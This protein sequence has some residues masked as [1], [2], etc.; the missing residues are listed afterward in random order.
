MRTAI[1]LAAIG[2]ASLGG[3][4]QAKYTLSLGGQPAGTATMTFTKQPNGGC[5]IVADLELSVQG[6]T[7][8]IQSTEVLDKNAR[9]VAFDFVEVAGGFSAERKMEYGAKALTFTETSGGKTKK[10]VVAYPKG[11][12]VAQPSDLWFVTTKPTP[13]TVSME[14]EYDADAGKWVSHKNVY[15]GTTQITV[16]GKKVKA[17]EINDTALS[18]G[19]VLHDWR[20]AHGL[21]YRLEVPVPGSVLQLNRILK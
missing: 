17:Y 19:R 18:D 20:D 8:H 21:P 9:P 11:K 12:S 15:V 1:A 13:H 3:A 10:K 5:K 16:G 2:L 7:T 4:T 6:S 14:E